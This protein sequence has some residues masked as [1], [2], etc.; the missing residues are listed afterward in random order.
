[1]EPL[2][3]LRNEHGLM[4]HYVDNLEVAVQHLEGGKQ[5]PTEF[6][7]KAVKFAREF[8][9]TF[10][11]LKEEHVMFVRLAQRQDGEMDGEIAAL[12]SQ[13][14]GARDYV[15][16]I[17]LALNGYDEGRQIQIEKVMENAN[18]YVALMRDHIHRED[19]LFFPLVSEKLTDDEM[20]QLTVEF[21]RAAEK[22]GEHVF[23]EHHKL[24]VDMGSML[25]HM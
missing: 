21:D 1:M 20:S 25:V 6:F 22:A 5:P 15:T 8:A 24:V 16:E 18:A 4:R 19:H 9:E 13:H 7:V 14:E 12:R 2:E 17:S 3:V 11:H 10:H 23:E